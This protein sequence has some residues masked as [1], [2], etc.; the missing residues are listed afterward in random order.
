MRVCIAAV[1]IANLAAV[2]IANLTDVG[3]KVES[4][5]AYFVCI[6]SGFNL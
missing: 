4:A 1:E 3:R 2:E 5:Q 6:A